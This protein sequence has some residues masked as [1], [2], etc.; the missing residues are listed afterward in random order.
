VDTIAA[1]PSHALTTKPSR[2][3]ELADRLYP[4]QFATVTVPEREN[5]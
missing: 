2:R 1:P 5:V 3:P 4:E